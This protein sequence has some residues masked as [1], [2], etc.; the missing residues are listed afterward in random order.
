MSLQFIIGGSGSGKTRT[1]YENL[2]RQSMEEPD[3]RFFALVP[4]QFTMQT[5]K[6]I[7]MLHPNHGVMNIDIVSFERLAYRVFEELAIENLA[8]LDDMGKSMVLRRVSSGV[9]GNLHLFGGHLDKAGFISEIKSMLSEFFQYGIT[10]EKLETLIGETKSPL[11]RQKLLD[12][13][14]LYRA[15][16]AYTEEKV[17]VKE[18]ILS[19]LCRVLPQ[20]QLI[21]DSIVT[22]DGYTGF[23]PIQYELLELL[24]RC[25]RKVIVTV[26]MDPEDNPYRES[27][28]QKLFYMSRHTV[29]RLIDRA[30][31]AGCSRDEDI[32]LKEKPMWRFKDSPEL[33]FIENELF[34][35]RGKVYHSGSGNESGAAAEHDRES[36]RLIEAATPQAEISFLCGEIRRLVASEGIRYREI[37][38]I[39]SDMNL[40]A[41][42]IEKTFREYEIPVFMDY[43]R[44]VLLNSFVEYIRSLLAMAEQNFSAESVFRFLRTDL[45]GFTGEELDLLENYVLALGIRGYKKWQEKWIRRAKDTT[46]EDLE[47]LN[48]LRVRFVEKTEDLVFVLKQRQKTV[49]DV[50][51]AVCEFL[52]K[53]EIQKQVKVLENQFTEA[54]EL[55]LAKEY[56]QIYRVVMDLFDKFVSLLGD[57]RIALKEYRELLDAGMEEARIGVIPPSLDEVMAGDIE[58]TRLKDIRALILL[59]VNDSLIPGNASAGGLISDRDRERFEERGIALAPGTREK[60]YIQKFYL[61]LHMTKPT[62]ELMLTYS[63]VSADGKSRRAA[64]LIGDLKRMYTKLPVFNM[65]KYGMETKEMLPQTG[66]GSLIE[67]LQNPKKME[68]GSWQELYRWYCAQEDWSEKVHDLARISRYRRPEDD[69]TLQTA[70][71][72]YGDWAPSISRLE[73]FAACA[74]AH[75]LTYGLR[76]KERE[77]YEFAAL[78]FGNIFHKALEKYARRVER[79]GLEWTEVTKEQQEQFASESVDESIVDYSNTVIYSSA[80]NAYIVPRMKRMMNRTVWAMT[81]QLRKGSFKPEGYEVSFGSGKIDRIDTCETEDQVYVKVLDYKT[82]AKSFDMA[83]FYHGLQMQLVVYMEEAVRLEERKHP[84]KKIVPAGIFYYRMK[85]PIVGKELDEEKLEEAILKELRLDGII[86]QE[87]AVIQRL[88]ADFS[89]NSLVIPAGKTKSGYSKASKMLL[90]EEFDAVLTY[91]EKRRTDLQ[92][93]MYRGKAEALPYEMGTQNGCAYCPYRDICGFDEQI[94]GYEYRKLEKLPKE[95]VMEKIMAKLEE[96]KQTWE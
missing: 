55:A 73:Q 76:L 72:L 32:L 8:V 33:G 41:D 74:C 95:I 48:H 3:G 47:V 36:L 44:N 86:R 10:E 56:A 87:D 23:T 22:L 49:R 35:Y 24:F 6:E 29:C 62:E 51:L 64:Y 2:I 7:V 96:E 53:E 1:L 77:V 28:Q 4:E 88:D 38:V 69:L 15:F 61:Y 39:A 89:G 75:F 68:E 11:L 58:R 79:E 84:G 13:Q 25:C 31:A 12:M 16:Q 65:D 66:I 27:V 91:A 82:G 21:R 50:T 30:A 60:S 34:R 5:Q 57:E 19:L 90:P 71:K 78:D 17:I 63:K 40:Y 37:A 14:V 43:K 59:G 93:A 67:G 20:S 81:K 9:R 42:E 92:G 94:E 54:G 80:R 45:T 85:D 26:T 46:E 70:R 18:E 52:E 83:A